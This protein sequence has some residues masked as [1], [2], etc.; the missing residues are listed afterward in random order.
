M[1]YFRA[2]K[3]SIPQ[4]DLVNVQ[5]KGYDFRVLESYQKYVEKLAENFGVS[6]N[7]SWATPASKYRVDVVSDANKVVDQLNLTKYE[8]NVQFENLPACRAGL[9]L[10]LLKRTLPPGVELSVHEHLPEHEQIR[11]VPDFELLELKKWGL[12]PF[13]VRFIGGPAQKTYGCGTS[14]T[15]VSSEWGLC[16]FPVRFIGGPAQ[17]TYGCGT[18]VTPVSS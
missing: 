9:M 17:K 16:P 4:Y 5:L 15:P 14:V 18:S 7:D 11:M 13:P 1:V 12:C 10:S 3:P 6:V 8:R 2:L